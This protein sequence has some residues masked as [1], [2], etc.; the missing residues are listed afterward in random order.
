MFAVELGCPFLIFAPRRL[1]LAG[2]MAIASLQFLTI[3][4]GNYAYFN[5]LTLALCIPLLDDAYLARVFP[6]TWRIRIQAQ[7][8]PPVR[9]IPSGRLR[10]AA[11]AFLAVTI[12]WASTERMFERFGHPLPGGDAAVLRPIETFRVI[13][14]YGLFEVM[15]TQR[16]EIIIEG[17]DDGETW[18]PYEFPY[19]PGNLSRVPPWVAP[20]QPRLDWQMWFAALGNYRQNQWF[21]NLMIRLLEGSPDVLKLLENNPFPDHP[22]RSLRASLYEY[23][24][25]TW[26]ERRTTGHWWKRTELG[27]YLP[28]ITLRQ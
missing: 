16:A 8:E 19:K 9:V 3:L 23:H 1:R 24:F 7:Y 11:V 5:L 26:S 22:P 13:S 6:K 15:T 21:I 4:T 20:H 17:S 14:A 10:R 2:A 28:A 12:L 18:K 25:T 27:E